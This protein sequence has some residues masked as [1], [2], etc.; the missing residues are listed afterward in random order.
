M[1]HSSFLGRRLVLSTRN[2]GLLTL[3]HAWM[4]DSDSDDDWAP[5]SQGAANVEKSEQEALKVLL[6]PNYVK[7]TRPEHPS[8]TVSLAAYCVFA[9]TLRLLLQDAGNQEGG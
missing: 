5:Q 2:S 9:C 4:Q 8:C 1:P 7:D 3:D 6:Q